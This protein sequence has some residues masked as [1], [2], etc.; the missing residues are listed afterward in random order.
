M[1]QR[2]PLGFQHGRQDINAGYVA[3]WPSVACHQPKLHWIAA[4]RENDRYDRCCG[5]SGERREFAA[6]RDQNLDRFA[7]KL[8]SE[9]G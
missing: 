4:D 9:L 3:A 8:C 6:G 1:E 5:L 7:R 2:E